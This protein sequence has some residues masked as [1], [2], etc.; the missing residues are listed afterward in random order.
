[1]KST[2]RSRTVLSFL[3]GRQMPLLSRGTATQ[4]LDGPRVEN[5]SRQCDHQGRP[6]RWQDKDG[7]RRPTAEIQVTHL[8]PGLQFPTAQVA[9]PTAEGLKAS[10]G[11]L[12]LRPS[13]GAERVSLG[14]GKA[15]LSNPS[16]E[17]FCGDPIVVKKTAGN[18]AGVDVRRSEITTIS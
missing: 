17:Q 11:G 6:A 18:G 9:K 8:E 1:M 12:G 15:G 4:G 7:N 5:P 10:A 2:R 13:R 3:L 16:R 14:L